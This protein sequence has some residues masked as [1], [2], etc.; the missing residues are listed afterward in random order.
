[1]QCPAS[2]PQ[3]LDLTTLVFTIQAD[4]TENRSEAIAT[5]LVSNQAIASHLAQETWNSLLPKFEEII[6]GCDLQEDKKRI[7]KVARLL[8]HMSLCNSSVKLTY[9]ELCRDLRVILHLVRKERLEECHKRANTALSV[10]VGGPHWG[11]LKAEVGKVSALRFYLDEGAR[12]R[13]LDLAGFLNNSPEDPEHM[14][15]L[16]FDEIKD[17]LERIKQMERSI[18][19]I[20]KIGN[21][22]VTAEIAFNQRRA[23]RGA[24]EKAK[25]PYFESFFIPY[26]DA[27]I[28]SATQ[29]LKKILAKDI[30]SLPKRPG[31]TKIDIKVALS[32]ALEKT[33]EETHQ[34]MPSWKKVIKLSKEDVKKIVTEQ[35]L[36]FFWDSYF[37]KSDS[38]DI[39]AYAWQTFEKLPD[40][41]KRGLQA[42][43]NQ[44]KAEKHKII[45]ALPDEEKKA[46]RAALATE[47]AAKVYTTLFKPLRK[48][49]P[50]FTKIVPC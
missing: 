40:E 21:Q 37:E 50:S 32:F 39:Q 28:A 2:A 27:A 18:L 45:T 30:R 43:L 7:I 6:T 46:V 13:L 25:G 9:N 44:I 38:F 20:S 26:A 10:G 41:K 19:D 16:L 8:Y 5:R 31:P 42:E 34:E 33:R 1:M 29:F 35:F 23:G 17:T 15:P 48:G 24:K 4:L 22:L 14:N 3:V 47:L 49:Q 11:E 36:N 12:Q